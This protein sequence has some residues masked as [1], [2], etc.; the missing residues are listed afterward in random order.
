M[1]KKYLF[2]LRHKLFFA[3]KALGQTFVPNLGGVLFTT[4]YD[5]PGAADG[6]ENRSSALGFPK[7][8]IPGPCPKSSGN[9]TM[10]IFNHENTKPDL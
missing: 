1:Y 3:D 2:R 7:A 6:D 8:Q 9:I 10:T 5:G 4:F